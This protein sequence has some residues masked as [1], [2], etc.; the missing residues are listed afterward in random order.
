M[1]SPKY[2]APDTAPTPETSLVQPP[3]VPA[4]PPACDCNH[5][6]APMPAPAPALGPASRPGV[7][8]TPGA[9]V[10]TVAGGTAVVLVVGAVLVSMLLAVAITAVS[11]ALCAIVLRSLLNSQNKQR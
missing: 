9:L 3:T 1:F 10:A 8:L 4:H 6:P 7:R 5:T 11:V 2:P